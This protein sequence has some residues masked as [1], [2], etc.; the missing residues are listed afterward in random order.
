MFYFALLISRLCCRC[1]WPKLI[2]WL[3][4]WMI[5]W[6]SCCVADYRLSNFTCISAVDSCYYLGSTRVPWSD[7]VNRCKSLHSNAHL[8]AI[9]NAAEQ[10]A[11]VDLWKN[12][13]G[14]G[15]IFH[16]RVMIDDCCKCIITFFWVLLFSMCDVAV[17]LCD[18]LLSLPRIH[19]TS[20]AYTVVRRL[21]VRYVRVLCQN[22]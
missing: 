19:C 9:N 3:S 12:H 5:D 11:V 4:E 20:V 18:K 7:A 22:G 16:L 2:D 14:D 21:S 1:P 8:V 15:I 13:Y 17:N 6:C 10:I